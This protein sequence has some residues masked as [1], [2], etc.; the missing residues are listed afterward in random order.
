MATLPPT[1]IT[2]SEYAAIYRDSSLWLPAMRAI[3]TRFGFDHT[4]L[5]FAPPG[6]H[7]VFRCGRDRYIKLYYPRWARSYQTERRVL[8]HIEKTGPLSVEVP[9][10]L[11][12][13]DVEGWPF[14]VLSEVPGKPLNQVWAS[15]TTAEHRQVSHEVGALIAELRSLPP[16][17]LTSEPVHGPGGTRNTRQR[18]TA[19][20]DP[21]GQG[22]VLEP[23]GEQ[24]PISVWPAFVR[25]QIQKSLSQMGS[26]TADRSWVDAA[27]ALA[28]RAEPHLLRQTGAVL[29]NADITDEHVMTAPGSDRRVV[30]GIIDFGDA[31][32]GHPLY[33]LAAP[34][35]SFAFGNRS[36]LLE[37]VRSAGLSGGIPGLTLAETFMATALIHEFITIPF[38]R[39]QCGRPLPATFA[40]LVSTAFPVESPP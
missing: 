7:V 37:M 36:L 27:T 40:E 32:I 3:C 29:L 28:A 23:P 33:E 35:C 19:E 8:E 31:M 25:A 38:L 11:G 5:E 13:G 18:P 26:E 15:L 22:G 14:L 20:D 16:C 30:T 4:Q 6:S 12:R 17:D 24:E 39:D 2:E 9:R 34:A 21:R 10:I 1:S